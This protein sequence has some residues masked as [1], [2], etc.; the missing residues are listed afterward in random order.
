MPMSQGAHLPRRKVYLS[1][2]PQPRRILV[3]RGVVRL[4]RAAS[5]RLRGL[6]V[7]D[8]AGV[9]QRTSYLLS[10]ARGH[11]PQGETSPTV[12]QRPLRRRRRPPELGYGQRRRSRRVRGSHCEGAPRSVDRVSRERLRRTVLG[13]LATVVPAPL[14]L[15]MLGTHMVSGTRARTTD[16]GIRR[17]LQSPSPRVLPLKGGVQRARPRLD[18]RL[19]A[20][21][22]CLT[23]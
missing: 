10:R 20:G 6:I 1:A 3:H 7:R 23:N 4:G 13:V 5:V 8:C 16:T 2:A 19:E 11:E 14:D 15:V 18:G 12:S 21:I 17:V 9:H 22:A